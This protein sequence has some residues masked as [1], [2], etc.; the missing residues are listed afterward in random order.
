MKRETRSFIIKELRA[1]NYESA[2]F[3]LLDE[4]TSKNQVVVD[5]PSRVWNYLL[6]Y[7]VKRQE[8]FICVTVN[9]K[10]CTFIKF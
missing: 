10:N 3:H 2:A 1:G 5:G 7:A 9:N 8:H 6:K 4:I